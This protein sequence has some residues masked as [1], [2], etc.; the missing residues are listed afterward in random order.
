MM[1]S[2][3]L[4]REH[5]GQPGRISRAFESFFDWTVAGYDSGLNWVFR[6]QFITLVSTIALVVVT[7]YLYVI[8]PKGFFP[9][10]DTGFLF[11]RNRS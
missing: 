10:Q 6:H 2:L 8:I 4:A 11:G 9:E 7:G 5:D 3:F 1:C